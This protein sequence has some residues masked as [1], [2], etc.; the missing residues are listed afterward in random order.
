MQRRSDHH[1][2]IFPD[3]RIRCRRADMVKQ[4]E[5]RTNRHV[6]PAGKPKGGYANIHIVVDQ[7]TFVPIRIIGF[8][9]D[10]F[11]IDLPFTMDILQDIGDGQMSQ[12]RVHSYRRVFRGQIVKTAD[13]NQIFLACAG[14]DTRFEFIV[15][16]AVKPGKK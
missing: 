5:V 8:T 16:Y 12:G 1:I 2:L 4:C 9:T 6:V 11:V 14:W 7:P 13:A 10:H 15:L 3:L